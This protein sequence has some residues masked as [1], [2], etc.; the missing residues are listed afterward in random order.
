MFEF[1]WWWVLCLI[2][3]PFIIRWL[4]KPKQ[5]SA[6]AALR[7]PALRP[8]MVTSIQAT[9]SRKVP[10]LVASAI[11]LGLAESDGTCRHA[12]PTFFCHGHTLR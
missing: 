12:L 1:A 4:V 8:N 11:W 7:V 5:K 6:L 3:L 2:P 10:L 9:K